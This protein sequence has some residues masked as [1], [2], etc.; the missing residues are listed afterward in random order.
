[1]ISSNVLVVE[2]LKLW[3]IWRKEE[4]FQRI[5]QSRTWLN[6]SDIFRSEGK[7]MLT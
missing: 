6:L 3:G 1:M 4:L 5:G 7:L 2:S